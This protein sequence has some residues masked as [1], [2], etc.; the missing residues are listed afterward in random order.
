M[1][2]LIA[3]ESL[4]F[5][6]STEHPCSYLAGERAQTV[7]MRPNQAIGTTTFSELSSFGFRRSGQLIYKPY[8]AQCDACKPVRIPVETFK[9]TRSQKRALKR[10]QDIKQQWVT[11]PNIDEH[12]PMYESYINERHGDGDMY[13]PSPTQYIEF[14]LDSSVRTRYMECRLNEQLIGCGV[15]DE[16]DNGL[17]AVYSYFDPKMSIRGLGNFIILA[18][19]EEA[20]KRNLAYVYLGYWIKESPKMNYKSNYRPMEIYHNNHWITVN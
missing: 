10:N 18:L 19:I 8:C 16:L 1:T 12:Y 4:E 5:L 14:L 13:P 9:P 11:T 17:S 3:L 20:K 6:K 2:D 7:M 15:V